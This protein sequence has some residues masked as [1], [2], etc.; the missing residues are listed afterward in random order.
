M[1]F[2][3]CFSLQLI[4]DKLKILVKYTS[5][6]NFVSGMFVLFPFM[7]EFDPAEVSIFRLFLIFQI[8]HEIIGCLWWVGVSRGFSLAILDS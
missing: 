1:Y 2:F 6:S 5:M 3:F 4:I 7:F 8:L